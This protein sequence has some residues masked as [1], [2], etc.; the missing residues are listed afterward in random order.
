MYSSV[1]ISTLSYTGVRGRGESSVVCY[2]R[3]QSP[4]ILMRGPRV[5]ARGKESKGRRIRYSGVDY[6]VE[7]GSSEVEGLAE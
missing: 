5:R 1:D 4:L 7:E 3:L 2:S 6:R